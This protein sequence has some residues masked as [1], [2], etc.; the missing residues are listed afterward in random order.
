MGEKSAQGRTKWVQLFKHSTD[1][2]SWGQP[3]EAMSGYEK[4]LN[5]MNTELSNAPSQLTD[6]ERNL[7]TKAK[8]CI[9]L[10]IKAIKSTT[11]VDPFPLE[12]LKPLETV[13][14]ALAESRS[15]ASFPINLAKYRGDVE[16]E[17]SPMQSMSSGLKGGGGGGIGAGGGGTLLPPPPPSLDGG[18]QLSIQIEKIGLKNAVQY[19]DPFITIQVIDSNGETLESTQDT[20]CSNQKK[21]NYIYYTCNVEIQT[22]IN[23]LPPGSAILFEFKHWKPKGEY[24]STK[25]WAFMELDEIKPG[26]AVLELYQKPT[27]HKRKKLRLLSVKPLYLHL[28]LKETAM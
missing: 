11:S 17:G 9:A 7:I 2:D 27:D 16:E 25:C 26:P 4:L 23:K 24:I 15:V 13:F 18:V 8:M 5:S 14:K 28:N 12:V 3:V 19:L 22:Q 21:E 10:R 1:S 20:P 6:E